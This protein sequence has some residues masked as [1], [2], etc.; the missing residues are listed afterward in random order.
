MNKRV[1]LTGGTGLIGKES[2]EYLINNGFEI[3]AITTKDIFDTKI[4]WIKCDLFDY[5]SLKKVFEDIKPSY[6]LNFAWITGDDYLTNQINTKFKETGLKL[7]EYFKLNGGIR[8]VYAGTCFEYDMTGEILSET[9]PVNPKTLYA[10]TKQEL[11]MECEKYA[12][13]NDLSFGW[14]R[15]FYV[16][17]HGEKSSRLTANVIECLTQN[18]VFELGAPNNLLDYMYTKDIAHAFVEFLK[19]DY[20]GTVNI[21][22]GKGILLKDYVLKFQDALGKKDLIKYDPNKPASVTCIGNNRILSNVIG[23]TPEYSIDKAIKEIVKP[24]L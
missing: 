12:T 16:F 22:T 23:F 5:T 8:A 11:H 20:N 7:L 3:Y 21:C 1:I 19:S 10:Q 17:G 2:F 14:G 4:N 18:K 6:L 24:F 15:I 9:S 13:E